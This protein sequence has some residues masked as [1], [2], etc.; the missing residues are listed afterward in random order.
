MDAA[1]PAVATSPLVHGTP[2]FA[3]S[4]RNRTRIRTPYKSA[5][6]KDGKS[7]RPSPRSIRN[8]PSQQ[9]L[10]AVK[11]TGI[12]WTTKTASRGASVGTK[13]PLLPLSERRAREEKQAASSP[14][15]PN[16]DIAP[17]GGSAGRE[18]R[19][20]TVANVGN[21]GRIYLRYVTIAGSWGTMG[22]GGRSL[23]V[24][25]VGLTGVVPPF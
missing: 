21:H 9:N 19:Q 8:P 13:L 3:R 24:S 17:D 15:L 4:R 1:Q 11:S 5:S 2:G 20:F 22:S 18:G 12:K 7:R 6:A 25:G 14:E 10:S 23:N 16:G